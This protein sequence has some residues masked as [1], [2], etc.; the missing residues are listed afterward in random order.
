MNRR[1][2]LALKYRLPSMITGGVEVGALLSY[3]LNLPAQMRRCDVYVEK[4]LKGAKPAEVP[5]ERPTKF[6]LTSI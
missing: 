6:D 3:A 1:A 5:V 2:A 4:I